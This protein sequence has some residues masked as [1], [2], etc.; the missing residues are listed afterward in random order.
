M[1][2]ARTCRA[3]GCNCH[4]LPVHVWS[5]GVRG[6]A[7]TPEEARGVNE[8]GRDMTGSRLIGLVV[9]VVV[10][11]GAAYFL[12]PGFRAKAD[13]MWAKHGGWNEEARKK[14]PVGF[15]R[16]SIAKLDEN[17]SKFESIRVDLRTGKNKL[18]KMG[19]ENAAKQTFAE[20]QLAAFKAAYKG[21]K[22]S[23]TW[24]VSIAGKSY[25]E[26]ELKSQVELLLSEK[27]TFANVG[28]QISRGAKD[29]EAK[30]FELV[31][32]ITESKS[33]L[34]LLKTQ[35]QL[36][37]ANKLTAET[38]KML[39]EVNDVLERNEAIN[40]GV[41]VRTTEE[42]MKEAKAAAKATPKADDFLN[43]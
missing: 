4:R 31:S 30:E 38:E 39:A 37:Q 23:G 28:E 15:I 33:K 42:L 19:Q 25:S 8:K 41:S 11:G 9:A 16:H 17:I 12:I 35:E 24:P 34:N 6:R 27:A 21:A 14:D 43:S 18:E 13:E 36:V 3:S 7:R 29:L 26:A 40:T 5:D 22:E 20:N 2:Q 10:I 32:R 1:E